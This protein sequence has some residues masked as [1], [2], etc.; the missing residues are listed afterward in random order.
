MSKKRE[1]TSSDSSG[2]SVASYPSNPSVTSAS[3]RD[4]PFPPPQ[5]MEPIREDIPPKV[6]DQLFWSPADC[7]GR[8]G[9]LD[10][11]KR[12]RRLKKSI[13]L[14]PEQ[15]HE[16]LS[17]IANNQD[18][19]G[20]VL[21]TPEILFRYVPS[22]FEGATVPRKTANDVLTHAISKSFFSIFPSVYMEKLKFVGNPKR[23]MY[24]LIWHEPQPVIPEA[25][26]DTPAFTLVEQ[27]PRQMRLQAVQPGSTI[28]A[29][30][31]FSLRLDDCSSTGTVGFLG[32]L[33]N[34]GPTRHVLTTA[35]HVI[36]DAS[37]VFVHN[38]NGI[39]YPLQ[40]VPEFQRTLGVPS[41]RISRTPTTSG[42]VSLNDM[43]LLETTHIP[44]NQLR[45]S[46]LSIDCTLFGS[47]SDISDDP[48]LMKR[49]PKA[50]DITK[51]REIINFGQHITVYKHG[52]I[53]SLTA[54]TLSYINRLD[55]GDIDVFELEV[56]W[57][58]PE[59][60]FAESGD[61]GSL[62]YAKHEGTIVPLGMHCGSEDTTNY[63]I[64]LWSFCEE[65]SDALDADLL[66]CDNDECGGGV[67][68]VL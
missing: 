41:F 65:I 8:K 17:F 67:S 63:A 24:E 12:K 27:E 30:E 33:D 10:R 1:N 64:S 20:N 5:N 7:P 31:S 36:E 59:T 6:S 55:G 25:L 34:L 43:C 14:N 16:I 29:R 62:V 68:G 32:T 50:S 42:N 11:I 51:L 44:P 9:V 23:R 21:W 15:L 2:P 18:E 3:S 49:D 60:P 54:G 19:G 58:A 66:F 56:D 37:S 4:S 40:I 45:C 39:P 52:A 38:A 46:F 57:D 48:A 61:S 13:S 22:D 35:G 47:D 53:T 26:R 28:A